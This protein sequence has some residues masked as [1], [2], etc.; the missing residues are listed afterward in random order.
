MGTLLIGELMIKEI[1]KSTAIKFIQTY[2]YSKILPRIPK[3]KKSERKR[4][5]F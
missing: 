5:N 2:H 4:P 3:I 1:D